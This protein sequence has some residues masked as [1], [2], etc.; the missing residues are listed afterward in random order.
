V[1]KVI[2]LEL[3][4][5][6]ADFRARHVGRARMLRGVVAAGICLRGPGKSQT[7]TK[8]NDRCRRQY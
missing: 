6:V 1:V 5:N 4:L 7:G 3:L 8:G 2:G